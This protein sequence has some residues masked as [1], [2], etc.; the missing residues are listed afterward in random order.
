MMNRTIQQAL[1][2]AILVMGSFTL[3][4]WAET[5]DDLEA[6]APAESRYTSPEYGFT[7]ARADD[8]LMFTDKDVVK[9]SLIG[10]I[11]ESGGV[12]EWQ[13]GLALLSRYPLESSL[14]QLSP[15][16]QVEVYHI[17]PPHTADE[18]SQWVAE[19]FLSAMQEDPEFGGQVKSKLSEVT[20][21]G[22]LWRTAGFQTKLSLPDPN[23]G[24]PRIM[25]ASV[26]FYVHASGDR[27]F[28]LQCIARA[29][30]APRFRR[31]F[32]SMIHSV[33]VRDVQANNNTPSSGRLAQLVRALP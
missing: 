17:E 21:N 4:V 27:L 20:I 8:W 24:D 14:T 22:V 31:D 11:I 19:Q 33:S 30:D 23:T 2:S 28:L 7:I 25:H 16:V 12:V 1:L 13:D 9:R 10:L 15:R 5:D 29:T 32:D 6:L 26:D 3:P 18:A